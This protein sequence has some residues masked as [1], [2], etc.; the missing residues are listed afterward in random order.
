MSEIKPFTLSPG[1]IIRRR[2]LHKTF[3]GQTQGGISTPSNGQLV[4]LISGDS[5]KQHGYSDEW[6]DDGVFLYTGE[7]QRGDMKFQAGNRAIR[8]HVQNQ[9]TLQLFEQNKKDKRFLRYIGEMEYIKHSF[10]DAPDTD[11][12]KRQAIVFHLR[13]VGALSPDTATVEAA[14]APE[15]PASAQRK[16]GGFGSV[17][18]NR[19]VEKA[20]VEF[21]QRHYERQGWKV[22]SVE[23]QKV[24]YDLRCEKDGAQEHVEVKGTQ[25]PEVGFI[26]TAGEVRNALID[27]RHVTGVVTSA[28]SDTPKVTFFSKSDFLSKI[29]LEPIAYRAILKG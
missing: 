2:E 13:P 26:I 6:T 29:E 23:A 15:L 14:L 5:G 7:G 17:E 12:A 22:I 11:G 16:G 4:I 27:Q 19:R 24:G 1:R 18:T 3:G 21:V 9:K 25:G 10:Q 20:A 28:L 8:D